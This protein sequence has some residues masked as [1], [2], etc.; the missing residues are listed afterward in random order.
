MQANA[1]MVQGL[2]QHP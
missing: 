2:F 1:N